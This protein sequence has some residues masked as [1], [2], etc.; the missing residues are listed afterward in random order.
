MFN[1]MSVLA[2]GVDSYGQYSTGAE[3]PWF[4]AFIGFFIL[5]ILAVRFFK[6]VGLIAWII[7]VFIY[8]SGCMGS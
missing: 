4:V 3:P 2:D 1:L 7:T 5:F 6:V 8:M